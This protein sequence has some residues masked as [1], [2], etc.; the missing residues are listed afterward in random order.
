MLLVAV[1]ASAPVGP[2]HGHFGIELHGTTINADGVLETEADGAGVANAVQYP[3]DPRVFEVP[4]ENPARVEPGP[5]T[6]TALMTV[7]DVRVHICDTYV[8]EYIGFAH[9]EH[10]PAPWY[11]YVLPNTHGGLGVSKTVS[12]N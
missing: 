7:S 9:G 12:P 10:D 6:V 1:V 8:F 2:D 3:G 5:H 11:L 4:A